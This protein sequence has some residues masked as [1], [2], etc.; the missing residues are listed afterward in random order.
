MD[1]ELI[2]VIVPVYNVEKYLD[3]CIESVINQSYTNIEIILV[4]DG[5]TDNSGI[6]IDEWRKKDDRI[7]VLHQN[8]SGLSAARNAGYKMS[9]GQYIMFVD[10]D[11]FLDLQMIEK[12][13]SAIK[14]ESAQISIC[15]EI[16]FME[17]KDI[18]PAKV[19]INE[20]KYENHKEFLSH[21]MDDFR[22]PFTWAWNKLFERSLIDG[23]AFQEGRLIEDLLF[24]T[25]LSKRI[26]KVVWIPERLYYY[27]QRETSIMHTNFEKRS[28][29][30]LYG[31]CY[32]YVTLKDYEKDD[33]FNV[34]HGIKCISSI[35][36]VYKEAKQI[37]NISV[38]NSAKNEYRDLY[39]KINWKKSSIK[40]WIKY[41]LIYFEV[42]INL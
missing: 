33:E 20:K 27:R 19:P 18:V 24:I 10:S 36:Q 6:L 42:L 29:D 34:L 30:Y 25:D 32:E 7:S 11:D 38:I 14:D 1:N 28:L 13:Y 2:S 4:D 23:I 21:F 35:H 26:K 8:N 15:Y 5:S 12:M 31:L 3:Q 9:K 40:K 17:N 16:A 22:G 39:K 41:S 37:K